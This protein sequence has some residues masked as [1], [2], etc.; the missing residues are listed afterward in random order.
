V[1]GVDAPIQFAG[2]PAGLV[3]VTQINYLIPAQAPTGAQPVV[4]T[5]GGVASPSAALTVTP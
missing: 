2:I 5:A 4:V 3:G 1:G